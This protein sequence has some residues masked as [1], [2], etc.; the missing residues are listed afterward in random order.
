MKTKFKVFKVK[1]TT[2]GSPEGTTGGELGGSITV[3][4]Y[5]AIPV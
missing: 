4:L 5:V 3:N 1:N 2:T